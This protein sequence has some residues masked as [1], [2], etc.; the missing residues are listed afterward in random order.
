M[1]IRYDPSY[2]YQKADQARRALMIPHTHGVRD[3]IS[4][5]IGNLNLG[6]LN[7][8][9]PK[10]SAEVNLWVGRLL[11]LFTGTD[12]NLE[13]VDWENSEWQVQLSQIVDNLAHA[14]LADQ[15]ED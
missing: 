4:A 7:Q 12:L 5:A 15:P 13:D 8:D 14:A 2:L 3:S 10:A 1:P 9:W 6:M 11:A